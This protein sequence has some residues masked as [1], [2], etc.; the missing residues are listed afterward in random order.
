MHLKEVLMGTEKVFHLAAE[1]G[2]HETFLNPDTTNEINVEG[3]LNVLELAKEYGFSLFVASKPNIWLNPYSISKE[4]A[5]KYA[6]VYAKEYG[7]KVAVLKWFSVYGPYQYVYKYQKAVPT[8]VN[9]AI[10]D[11][12]IFVYGDGKQMADFVWVEDAIRAAD[13]IVSKGIFGEVIEY[14]SGTGTRV[15]DLVE[16]IIRLTGSKSKIKYLPMRIGEDSG[17]KVYA[18]TTRAKLLIGVR[19]TSLEVGLKKTIA[20]YRGKRE[21]F[22]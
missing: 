16:L 18:N 2:T 22:Y 1:L 3:T 12:P 8:F 5:E 6:L 20:F 15:I 10:K 11:M 7:V 19:P 17:S 9:R 13:E 21:F 4:A 14:G